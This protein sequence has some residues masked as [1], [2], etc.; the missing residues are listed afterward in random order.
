MQDLAILAGLFVRPNE[1]LEHEQYGQQLIVKLEKGYVHSQWDVASSRVL[2][3]LIKAIYNTARP[4]IAVLTPDEADAPLFAIWSQQWFKLRRNFRFQTA[5]SHDSR[6]P[7]VR[8]D[9]NLRLNYDGNIVSSIVDDW[10]EEAVE[11]MLPE[12]HGYLRSFL[13]NYGGDVRRQRGSFRPLVTIYLM[14]NEKKES[15]GSKILEMITD[16]FPDSN[17]AL[18]LKQDIIDGKIVPQAQLDVLWLVLESEVIGC[19]PKPSKRGLDRLKTM[20]IDRPQD[21]LHLAESTA[22]AKG[23]IGQAIF[24]AI[25]ESVTPEI[26]WNLTEP[27]PNLQGRLM[28]DRVDLLASDMVL[29]LDNGQLGA[30]MRIIPKDYVGIQELV[31]KM[32]SRDDANLVEILID[33]FPDAVACEV[34]SAL[35]GQMVEVAA[36][37]LR[38]LVQNPQVLLTVDVMNRITHASLFFEIASR[39]GWLSNSVMQSGVDPWCAV[40]NGI[41]EDLADE[42]M[43]I[44]RT[45]LIGLAIICGGEGGRRLIEQNFAK[46]HD[47]IIRSKLSWLSVS[48]LTPCLPDIG[49]VRAW[50][51]GLRLR[52]AVAELY[53]RCNYPVQ[54]YVNLVSDKRTRIL[55]SAAADSVVGGENLFRAIK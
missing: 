25:A 30:V 35:N 29:N 13:W 46:V 44:L 18:S 24:E 40:L 51:Y 14:H 6:L 2:R 1:N 43:D 27:Y 20:W 22:K 11:D 52:V 21:L 9:I 12:S 41:N 3:D 26:F 28:K 39:L 49:W 38:G 50:D 15:S 47:L 54:S 10:V 48:I 36:V 17:D 32:L 45:F 8:W 53:V 23:G 16:A 42:K 37:W 5:V 4:T 34:V 19:F 31:P 55:L 7:G 33:R